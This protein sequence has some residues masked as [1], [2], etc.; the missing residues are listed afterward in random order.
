MTPI[1]SGRSV[2]AVRF[3][4]SLEGS[5]RPPTDTAGENDRHSAARRRERDG[6][7]APPMIADAGEDQPEPA[8][9]WWG[10][11]ADA[12]REGW[13]DRVGRTF[14]AGSMVVTRREADLARA[15]FAA[16]AAAA[17]AEGDAG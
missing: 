9:T 11:L 15:A 14:E 16:H 12:E 7:G 3:D 6:D 13:A 1:K 4:W 2:T 5:T 8:L 10:G 17:D